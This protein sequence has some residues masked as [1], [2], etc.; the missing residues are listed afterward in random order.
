METKQP[1][2]KIFCPITGKDIEPWDCYSAALVYEEVSP[3]SE[4][5][6]GMTFTDENQNKCLKCKNH[7]D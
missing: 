6:K 1:E 7:P 4:L 2:K 5:P 3:L